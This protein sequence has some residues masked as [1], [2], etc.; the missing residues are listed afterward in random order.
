MQINSSKLRGV[1][2]D[3]KFKALVP[4]ELEG[5]GR[6]RTRGAVLRE[7]RGVGELRHVLDASEDEATRHNCIQAGA[8]LG[9]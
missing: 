6:A 9:C 7:V 4:P 1:F 3:N 5:A 2:S 8:T